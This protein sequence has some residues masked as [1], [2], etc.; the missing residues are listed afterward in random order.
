MISNFNNHESSVDIFSLVYG[1]CLIGWWSGTVVG[2]LC[3]CNSKFFRS[4]VPSKNLSNLLMIS[5]VD[6]GILSDGT[7]IAAVTLGGST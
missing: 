1:T 6:G 2:S 7:L 3:S 4:P 5:Y